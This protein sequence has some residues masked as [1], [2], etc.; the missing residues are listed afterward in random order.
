[1][2]LQYTQT[3]VD[4]LETSKRLEEQNIALRADLAARPSVLFRHM[5]CSSTQ[6]NPSIASTGADTP[7]ILNIAVAAAP[8]K[9]TQTM[10]TG[11]K[12]AYEIVRTATNQ[13]RSRANLLSFR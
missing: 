6:V 9:S 13:P 2:A 3:R 10:I 1:M 4:S 5:I 11:I 12:Q 8:S 7:A